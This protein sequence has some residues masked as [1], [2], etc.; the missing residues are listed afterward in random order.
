MRHLQT[1]LERGTWFLSSG[2]VSRTR[3]LRLAG[4]GDTGEHDTLDEHSL[5]NTVTP[6]LLVESIHPTIGRAQFR[7]LAG[8]S[9]NRILDYW[10][11]RST[12]A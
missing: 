7:Q 8:Q 9:L 1:A 11:S 10:S 5:E 4:S 6:R 12:P 3:L 2:E